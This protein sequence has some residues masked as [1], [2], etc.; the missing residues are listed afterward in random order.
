MGCDAL[1]RPKRAMRCN[2][3]A[4]CKASSW[5]S[6][7]VTHSFVK[8][9]N[10]IQR[11]LRY[12]NKCCHGIDSFDSFL[13]RPLIFCGCHLKFTWS[14][15]VSGGYQLFLTKMEEKN[16]IGWTGVIIREIPQN[17]HRLYS[18]IPPIW[19][20]LWPLLKQTPIGIVGC[21]RPRSLLW[22]LNKHPRN[23]DLVI[24]EEGFMYLIPSWLKSNVNVD[25]IF[26]Y[27]NIYHI[28]ECW[29][30]PVATYW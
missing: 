23:P 10:M 26:Q 20:I 25:T 22:W 28:I 1:I 3:V 16:H 14:Q 27:S 2:A 12:I 24:L 29:S 15:V 8:G 5:S 19:V 13:L 4:A 9:L 18:L 17:Y 7:E 11:R 21:M 6:W 30:I